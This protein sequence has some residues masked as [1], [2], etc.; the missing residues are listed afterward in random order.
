MPGS[1]TVQAPPNERRIYPIVIM[2]TLENIS[3]NNN[4]TG[5]KEGVSIQSMGLNVYSDDVSKIELARPNKLVLTISPN[6]YGI[7]TKDA[8]FREALERADYLVLDGVYFGLAA[9]IMQHKLIKPNRGP[10]IFN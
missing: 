7:A 5:V 4:A 2:N 3:T 10:D 8:L 1:R 6:S 9:L